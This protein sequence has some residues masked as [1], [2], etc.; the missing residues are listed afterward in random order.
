MRQGKVFY[1][2]SLAGTI[3]EIH[4]GE[5]VF[6][7]DPSYVKEHSDEFITFTMPVTDKPYTE[8]QIEGTFKRM[9]KN[10]P[11]ALE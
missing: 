8:K 5:D 1:K 9:V 10:Y 2:D 4:G 3:T 7:Y 11:K 6:Q